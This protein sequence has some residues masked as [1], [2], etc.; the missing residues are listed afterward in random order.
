MCEPARY[1]EEDYATNLAKYR[2][3]FHLS[4]IPEENVCGC[5]A[6]TADVAELK[7]FRGHLAAIQGIHQSLLLPS[8]SS[9]AVEDGVMKQR[10]LSEMQNLSSKASMWRKEIGSIAAD[11]WFFSDGDVSESMDGVQG[12]GEDEESQEDDDDEEVQG[13]GEEEESPEGKTIKKDEADHENEQGHD[14]E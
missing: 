3:Y 5:I 7:R 6:C 9:S 1:P 11:I 13:S 2:F 12:S 8:V 10:W 4:S 14:S